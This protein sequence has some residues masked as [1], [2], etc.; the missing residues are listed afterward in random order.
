MLRLNF[1]NL[2]T[3][4]TYKKAKV[5]FIVRPTEWNLCVPENTHR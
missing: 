5:T 3:T 2:Y 1:F 4:I